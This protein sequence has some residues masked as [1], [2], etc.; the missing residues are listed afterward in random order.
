MKLHHIVKSMLTGS[1]LSQNLWKLILH[2]F[3]K[4]NGENLVSIKSKFPL[5]YCKT[6][7]LLLIEIMNVNY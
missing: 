1:I 3:S 7:F 4:N 6:S 2:L 5:I